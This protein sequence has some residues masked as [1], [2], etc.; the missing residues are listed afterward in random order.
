MNTINLKTLANICNDKEALYLLK[1]QYKLE[2]IKDVEKDCILNLVEELHSNDRSVSYLDAFYLNYRIKQINPEFDLLKYTEEGVL[3]IELKSKSNKTKILRQQ[4]KNYF[5]LKYI[6]EKVRIITYVS[7]ENIFYKYDSENNITIKINTE[8]VTSILEEFRNPKSIHLDEVF[9]PSNYL[10]SPFNDTEK[11]LNNKYILTQHQQ[12][13]VRE[14]ESSKNHFVIEGKAGTGKSLVLYNIAKKFIQTEK[15]VMMIHCG[16]LNE[17][18]NKLNQ[19]EGWDIYSI[20]S[21]N[22]EFLEERINNLDVILLDEVQ[23][24]NPNQLKDIIDKCNENDIRLIFSLDPKQYLKDTERDYNNLAFIKRV[25]DN[26]KHEKLTE[27]IRSNREI[28]FFIKEIFDND[29]KNNLEYENVEI[30]FLGINSDIEEYINYLEDISWTYLP[31]TTSNYDEASFNNYSFLKP[32]INSH[33]VIGQEFENVAIIL[34]K[35]FAIKDKV[36]SYFG[37]A[38]YYNPVQMVF[39]NMTR[40]RT[41]LK[42]IVIENRELYK[43]LMKIVTKE[44][45]V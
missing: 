22:S 18:H 30:D 44:H 14:I 32:E 28:A 12:N 20:R 29:K 38:Y 34:D 45:N 25:I 24:L 4:S 23:R 21:I 43:N 19:H 16:Y 35:S 42:L 15:K 40:T 7:D 39:Q 33:K 37:P 27:K 1:K 13:M 36:L 6:S 5:Y 10:I 8:E 11:F 26:I 31:L 2:S 41:K 3:N 9:Q 17:G